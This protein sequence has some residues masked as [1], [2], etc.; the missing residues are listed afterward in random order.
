[1]AIAEACYQGTKFAAIEDPR[2]EAVME[3]D[4]R[5]AMKYMSTEALAERILNMVEDDEPIEIFSEI[6]VFDAQRVLLDELPPRLH[7]VAH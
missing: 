6:E 4:Q 3:K 1:M 7:N 2:L 5:C